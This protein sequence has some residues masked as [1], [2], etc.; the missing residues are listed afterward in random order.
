MRVRDASIKNPHVRDSSHANITIV[1]DPMKYLTLTYPNGGESFA[2]GSV[3]TIRWTTKGTVA[4]VSLKYSINGGLQWEEMKNAAGNAAIDIPNNGLFNWLV[5]ENV[6]PSTRCL[7]KIYDRTNSCTIDYNNTF[8]EINNNPAITIITPMQNDTLFVG[9]N[10]TV[11]WTRSNLPTDYVNVEYS[12]NNGA[13]WIMLDSSLLAGNSFSWTVPATI[14]A[15]GILRISSTA[16][17]AINS[18]INFKIFN[19]I[20]TYIGPETGNV[21]SG[22]AT[23]SIKW[24]QRGGSGQAR[25]D[26]SIDG[27]KTWIFLDKIFQGNDTNSYNW[28]VPNIS[29]SKLAIRVTD[30]TN[31]QARDSSK[32]NLSI[33]GDAT[34][35][36]TLTYPNGGESVSPGSLCTIR[37][38]T[39]GS[40]PKIS[41]FYSLDNGLN[42]DPLP[43]N[44]GNP[45]LV[46]TGAYR[47]LV[48]TNLALYSKCRIKIVDAEK[49]CVM[50]YNDSLFNIGDH[51]S[52]SILNPLPYE[53]WYVGRHHLLK[54]SHYNLP[55]SFI[56]IEF[57]ID[58][59]KKWQMVDSNYYSADNNR[60]FLVPNNI[61][62]QGIIRV[63]ATAD[64]T[65][66]SEINFKIDRC[67]AN[68]LE[69]KNGEQLIACTTKKI[70]WTQKGFGSMVIFDY[71][72]DG[73]KNWSYI[74]IGYAMNDTNTYDWLV[75]NTPS[76]NA[77]IR[78]RDAEI[79]TITDASPINFAIVEDASTTLTITSPKGG[80]S[81]SVNSVHP[82]TWNTK[83]NIGNV[84]IEF[85]TNG[86][87]NWWY[88]NNINGSTSDN[89]TNTGHFEWLVPPNIG[90][91]A[92]CLI[93]IYDFQS[94]C[95]IDY[96]DTVFSVHNNSNIQ[97]LHPVDNEILYT[98][99]PCIIKWL[100]SYLPSDYLNI[101]YSLDNG[102]TWTMIDS[103]LYYLS[104]YKFIV[105]NK[106]TDQGIIRVSATADPSINDKVK[107]K[108]KPPHI[109]LTSF[110]GG[111]T[112][113]GCDNSK[114]T[115]TYDGG[116][117]NAY[118]DYSFDEGNTWIC[119]AKASQ[120][121]GANSYDWSVPGITSNKVRI[122]IRD[123]G[124][125]SVK[126]VSK[127]N[128]TILPSTKQKN[129]TINVLNGGESISLSSVTPIRWSTTGS[130]GNVC[131]QYST[132][133]GLNWSFLNDV[134]GNTAN[135]ITNKGFFYWFV[136]RNFSLSSTCLI[137]IYEYNEPCII[138][139]NDAF[140]TINNNASIAIIS[141][142]ADD[143]YY[144]GNNYTIQWSTS[145]DVL[146]VNVEYSIDNGSTW[147]VLDSNL[148]SGLFYNWIIPQKLTSKGILKV[149]STTNP[150]VH[151]AINFKIENPS[152]TLLNPLGGEV[153]HA[154]DV[155]DI[156]WIKK[157]GS[158][159]ANIDYSFDSGKNWIL[160]MRVAQL[161]DTNSFQLFVPNVASDKIRIRVR[162]A[163]KFQLTDSSKKDLTF[164]ADAAKSLTLTY[165]NGSESFSA[166]SLQ[167]IR[168]TTAGTVPYVR[169]FYSINGGLDWNI[170]INEKGQAAFVPNSGSFSWLVP[171]NLPISSRC[172]IKIYEDGGS[173]VMDYNDAFFSIDHNPAIAITNPSE[174]ETRY[175]GNSYPIEWAKAHL[176]NEY[177]TIEYSIDKG[178]NWEMVDSNAT[179]TC[180]WIIP[181]KVTNEGMI[182]ARATLDNTTKSIV[183]FKIAPVVITDVT[184]DAEEHSWN[185][186]PNPTNDLINLEHPSVKHMNFT[187]CLMNANGQVI[188]TESQQ[189]YSGPYSKKI[190]I[191]L[192]NAG[193]YLLRIIT[194]EQV[195]TKKII[196]N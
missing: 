3:N 61:T 74:G 102:T 53:T 164:I 92:N 104:V 81:F 188:Y 19:P 169:L 35:N 187:I 21:I 103:N 41:L 37:W 143:T 190:N 57:S 113:T 75:P 121:K 175:V 24:L 70:K 150:V 165:P 48:P 62:D 151:H 91:Y 36:L 69:I 88:L 49:E 45:I 108:I 118:L 7:I 82:I 161:K 23:T 86:G 94:R 66:K 54:W 72:T 11:S 2:R 136:P 71:S 144:V 139:Y 76:A 89:I 85:S 44:A 181:N 184:A 105:P 87:L 63:S 137:K 171:V 8:F 40:V 4:E 39:N 117:A 122:Q 106:L 147:I 189:Q 111:E 22:C 158:D 98:E 13:K 182:R 126:D 172:L 119:F 67:T 194:D 58:N 131:L 59:G 123:A 148:S 163:S 196:K 130:V 65:I 156:V 154:C 38:S 112:F 99:E 31:D 33:V 93:K 6:V 110:T 162:D 50:D 193:I 141:P 153:F 17:T 174:G 1:A 28:L 77:R 135:N 56:N 145:D 183:N 176:L 73:G 146:H 68:I 115:W 30:A 84:S 79:I 157:G 80:E 159:W 109:T 167:T 129:L 185:I 96:T 27:K 5:P 101:D 10:Y 125:A 78:L 195:I 25:I 152:M 120:T 51:P 64:N 16:N 127:N 124:N 179:N 166:A 177:V 191:G 90:A 160:Y 43:D 60:Y 83:G 178:K 15:Q 116:A 186:Y 9:K 142:T 132:D 26:Y 140:F 107:F 192:E 173:C 95:L 47:W 149:S 52:I 134:S 180:N 46:N 55:T 34:T 100:Y 32:T 14:T 128:I 155:E 29:S 114:I 138:D 42:W 12:I 133:G 170:M 20:I 18:R 168:W 97:I